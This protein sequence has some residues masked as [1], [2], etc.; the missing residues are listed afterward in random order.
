M[1]ILNVRYKVV[2]FVILRRCFSLG[3]SRALINNFSHTANKNPPD[4][5]NDN[6]EDFFGIPEDFKL[7]HARHSLQQ[8]LD[9]SNSQS[10]QST[11]SAESTDDLHARET[12]QPEPE[13]RLSRKERRMSEL[14][15]FK[16]TFGTISLDNTVSQSSNIN[17]ESLTRKAQE[18]LNKLHTTNFKSPEQRKEQRE[19]KK[20]SNRTSE[21]QV[22]VNYQGRLKSNS[23][24]RLR[25]AHAPT[26]NYLDEVYFPEHSRDED[27]SISHP[28]LHQ[29]SQV[30]ESA[31][32][33][34]KPHSSSEANNTESKLP[35]DI[36]KHDEHS[37]RSSSYIDEQYFS[38]H[39][40]HENNENL[41]SSEKLEQNSWSQKRRENSK[42][43]SFEISSETAPPKESH[44]EKKGVD[45]MSADFNEIND[46]YFGNVISN[47]NSKN[48][49]TIRKTVSSP[50]DMNIGSPSLDEIVAD[51]ETN[52]NFNID[53][54]KS[55]LAEITHQQKP[56]ILESRRSR[57]EL[58]KE[59]LENDHRRMNEEYAQKRL[60]N[61]HKRKKKE[62]V[63]ERVDNDHR[64]MN[65]EPT[66]KK[67]DCDNGHHITME[68]EEAAQPDITDKL[69]S[70]SRRLDK[71]AVQE[72]PDS[73]SQI[74]SSEDF[75]RNKRTNKRVQPNLEKPE[76]AYDVAMKIRHGLKAGHLKAEDRLKD[77]MEGR[78]YNNSLTLSSLLYSFF[79]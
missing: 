63:K 25:N 14:T 53:K 39:I 48:D 45:E 76:T 28:S 30:S 20:E 4:E 59:K 19:N 29:N 3:E 10:A 51:Y 55:P 12:T 70:A 43:A 49:N 31:L 72:E 32:Q 61:D 6:S 36:I 62:L 57:E 16:T 42:H 24:S 58:V 13:K 71:A 78:H 52:P 9:K 41:N 64:R 23:F 18:I 74:L 34:P 50:V 27:T 60:E 54:K 33:S 46:Q 65:E 17:T 67:L 68:N 77:F 21:E 38:T 5:E 22:N 26:S 8:N 40:L 15:A 47:F 73:D 35:S 7:Q 69:K 37:E 2:N 56:G 44:T 11:E 1:K 79:I 75:L 66:Q